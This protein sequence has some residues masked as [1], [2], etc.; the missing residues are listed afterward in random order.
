VTDR[1][2]ARAPKRRRVGERRRRVVPEITYP[3]DLPVSER[4][5]EIL[6]AL[7]DHQVVVVAGETGSGKTT[8]LPKICL[9][10]GRGVDGMIGHTQPRRL[11]AR[12][13][14][15]R[16]AAELGVPL[17]REVGYTV[18]FTDTVSDSTLVKVMTDG[19]LL[20]ETRRDPL[21]SSYDTIIVDE[22]HE[23]SL[24]IDFLLGYLR[25]LLPRRLDLSVVITSATID[26][27]RFAAHFDAPV[28]EVAGRTH[29]V[30]LSYRPLSVDDGAEEDREL[31]QALCE[32]VSELVAVGPGDI[33]VFLPGER[34]IRDAAVALRDHGP[35]GLEIVPLYAR[36]SGAEQHRVFRPH[37]GRRVVLA[38]NVAET[39]L[40]VPGIRFVID[41]GLARI[42]RYS[43]RTKVQRLPIEPVSRASADQ[44]AGR[45]GRIAPGH[46][47]RLYSEE[48]YASRASFTDP[49]ILRTNLASVILQMAAL[50]LGEIEDFPFMEP[51]DPS[52]IADGRAVLEE[53]GAFEPRAKGMHLTA[54]GRRVAELPLD[55]RLA[56]MVIEGD[57]LGCRREVTVI[58]AALSVKDPRERPR[59][60]EA[61]A[62]ELHRRF[63]VPGS[64][65]LAYVQLW[66]YLAGLQAELSNNQFRRRCRAEYLNVLAVREWQD[67]VSQIRRSYRAESG[68]GA[69][70]P[71]RAEAIHR[72]LLAGLLSQ[73][74]RRD[75]ARG[76][77]EGARGTRF[78][79]G[80]SSVLSKAKPAWVMAAELIETTGIFAST[81][82]R[83][84]PA[85]IERAGAH[86]VRRSYTA[87]WWD[88]DRVE[89]RVHERVTLYGLPVVERRPVSLARVDPVMARQMLIEEGLLAGEVGFALDA[90]ER[91]WSRVERVRALE[92]RVR[93]P[94]LYAGD[95]ALADFYDRCVPQDV[96]TGRRLER[97]WRGI[98]RVDPKRLD[99][100]Y[101]VLLEPTGAPV[102]LSGY[103]LRWI[104]GD[105]EFEVRYR[106]A[107]GEPDDGVSIEV[108]LS[109]LNRVVAEGF[110]WQVPGYR[111]ELVD[112]LVRT[113]P[114]PTRRSLVPIADTVRLVLD[115]IDPADGP[116][117]EV[118]A[119]QLSRLSG[120][121]IGADEFDPA[122][123]PGHLRVAFDIV[124]EH[125]VLVARGEDLEA[126]RRALRDQ[127]RASIR[128]A[129]PF[130]E[131]TG[132]TS[133]QFGEIERRVSSGLVVGYPALTDEADAVGLCVLD[134]PEAQAASMWLG[135]RRLLLLGAPVPSAHVERRVPPATTVALAKADR[136]LPALVEDC[137]VAAVDEII[138]QAGGPS[139]GETGYA[140]MLAVARQQLPERVA[141]AARV[142]AQAVTTAARLAERATELAERDRAGVLGPSLADVRHQLEGLVGGAFVT[143][144]GTARLL[145]L[146]R[147]LEAIS[148][149]LDR[150]P[151]DVRRDAERVAILDSVRLPYERLRD[152]R[153]VG[154]TPVAAP[155]AVAELAFLIEELR[156]SLFAQAL[157]TAVPVSPQ[158]IRRVLERAS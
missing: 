70:T 118:L 85:W 8:Q 119:I 92:E 99:V 130:F 17:G 101:G 1:S 79:I 138:A 125:G 127:I 27:A 48:D 68:R 106:F 146:P 142:A 63:V 67:L 9:E 98:A 126:L 121:T 5:G 88:A 33:L 108:P 69:A 149:R 46:C 141:A 78:Q 97:W 32:V 86:L 51:P 66:D 71:A 83:V 62:D 111:S 42:S 84:E 147:Y 29:P 41:S 124:D 47:V 91:N 157:G 131:H 89:A 50:G 144:W 39:S 110:D 2:S 34:D 140:S 77:Y 103:P 152:A 19:I 53:I 156:V 15:E 122:A 36:L 115:R 104:Q 28:V 13:V 136:P 102:D 38:T 23:R 95:E 73:V 74:G 37:R 100:P 22:A 35:E 4:R 16:L 94:N 14:A 65:L 11:A 31:N 129:T 55:P 61:A 6:E 56:R 72:A 116:L 90:L 80:R 112:A 58:A 52:S 123:L 133:W 134:S 12:T 82:A 145:E 120:A 24:N 114:K 150:L 45:C 60:H 151:R 148:L 137:S 96:T 30:T 75:T 117:L 143:R 25:R 54:V 3:E 105:L 26:T 18:R 64:D 49:E 81:L 59:E 153:L 57:Q 87:P 135:T 40:T 20:A 76:D 109:V 155:D 43:R 93:R 139:F 10:L 107:P 113:L 21:L 44:R 154:T 132:A 7:R 158:R 128:R